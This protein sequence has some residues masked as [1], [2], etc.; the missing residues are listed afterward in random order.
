MLHLMTFPQGTCLGPYEI[1]SLQG[2]GGMGQVYRA[3]DTRLGRTVAI[4]VLP[5][6]IADDPRRSE[7]FDREARVIASL[8][9]P[10]ICALFD[11]GTEDDVQYLVME[12]LEGETLEERLAGQGLTPSEAC[13][14]G[15]QIADSL[16]AAH[17]KGIIHRDLKPANIFL[18]AN[19]VKV[20]DFG[21]AKFL[22][23]EAASPSTGDLPTVLATGRHAI[24]GT[25]AYM[26]PEQARGLP[27]DVRT[28][29][30]SFGAVLFEM[31]G[32]VRLFHG[33]TA[34]DILSAVLRDEI[35][36][37]A[38]PDEISP[39][40]RDLLRRLLRR[41]VEH[42]LDDLAEA[43]A[44]LTACVDG[45]SGS[46][47]L[48][49]VHPAEEDH[50]IA[51]IPFANNSPD[52][53]NEY[54]SDGLTEEVI[55][56]LSRID[57]LRVIS[58]TTAMRLKGMEKDLRTIA[59][60]LSVRYI[61]EGSVRK[62]GNKLRITAQLIDTMTDTTVWADKYSGTLDDVFQIQEQVSRAIV[63]SLRVTLSVEEERKLA[64][65]TVNPQA[66]D[67]FLRARRD[68][69]TFTRDGLDR[70]LADLERCLSSVGEDVLLYRGLGLANFQYVNAG[71]SGDQAYIDK[72]EAYARKILALDP[73]SSHGA[74]LLGYVA[75]QRGDITAWLR[76]FERA[77]AADPHNADNL[78][79]L[80]LGWIWAGHP[81]RAE[82]H[83][84]RLLSVDPLFDL[85][86]YALGH[87]DF[88]EGRFE[89]A[90]PLFMKASKLN[91]A[92]PGWPMVKAQA[93]ASV[94]KL[95]QMV[96]MVAETAQAPD[97]HP[98]ARLAHVFRH[99]AA[100]EAG[101]ADELTN[102][103]FT[104]IIWGDLQYTHIMAQAQAL[105]GRRDEGFKWLERAVERGF[106]SY[107]YLSAI[108]PLIE[109][110]RSDPRFAELM[111][112]VK[113]RWEGLPAA[114]QAG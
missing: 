35:D 73:A 93:L 29:A 104:Q 85:V 103:E 6:L 58:R 94:G 96:A 80:T 113:T 105:L 97:E 53:D 32:G 19:G 39:P 40:V 10:H 46:R 114:V 63:E 52:P 108:D 60:E 37:S 15:A 70:A 36:W 18:T 17:L 76:Q 50:S 54:F 86:Q 33:D 83:L 69:W 92:H 11:I 71:I 49:A 74:S 4:K 1:E 5:N 90:L 91:P 109:N 111:D 77:A 64:V 112:R 65:P 106:I 12:F 13:R 45:E 59:H 100:G 42:R 43:A 110:L 31:L 9:H 57:A 102:D 75:C 101:L 78:V 72:A 67:C 28:D 55:S 16:K 26:S 41:D 56:D 84:E 14:A 95:D 87:K 23:P 62:M 89:Q 27:L 3:T 98:L 68:I 24:L 107:P 30:W 22:D 21:L 81:D 8:S 47:V 48:P 82:R 2:E 20:L 44:V 34:T 51:V 99:A 88:M 38:L 7:R 79:W 25:P 66:Y 61:L